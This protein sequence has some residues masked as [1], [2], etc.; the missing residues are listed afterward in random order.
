MKTFVQS[1]VLFPTQGMITILAPHKWGYCQL[2]SD[3][4][5]GK[6]GGAGEEAW[7][8]QNGR[9]IAKHS[10]KVIIQTI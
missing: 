9:Y 7:G 10:N 5:Q 6:W 1:F 4:I 2:M 3:N 8:Q